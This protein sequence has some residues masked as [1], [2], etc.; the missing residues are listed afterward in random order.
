[1]EYASGES[2]DVALRDFTPGL[3]RALP[4]LIDIGRAIDAAWAEGRGHGALHPRDV[5]VSTG[6]DTRITGFG[7]IS[8]LESI[9]AQVV[10]SAVRTPRPNAPTGEVWGIRADVY[11]LGA[12]AHELLTGRRPLG[13][14]E[15]DGTLAPELS[16][17]QRVNVRRVIGAALAEL[18]RGSI[19]KRRAHSSRLWRPS[20][21]A[22]RPSCRRRWWRSGRPPQ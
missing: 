14:G 19:R 16:P 1:M 13:S 10:P 11:S 6:V 3:G 9:G 5:I 18:P 7:I 12:I 21:A 4:V 20:R 22:K 15:Q 8:A 17:E 2:L